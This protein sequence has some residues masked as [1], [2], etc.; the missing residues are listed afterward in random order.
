MIWGGA[1]GGLFANTEVWPTRQCVT[2]A[3]LC[4]VARA[5]HSQVGLSRGS[6]GDLFLDLLRVLS[7]DVC[8]LAFAFC[9]GSFVNCLHPT[10]HVCACGNPHILWWAHDKQQLKLHDFQIIVG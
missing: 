6:I 5:R 2:F 9:V 3:C 7:S 4:C 8:H 1:I 10:T